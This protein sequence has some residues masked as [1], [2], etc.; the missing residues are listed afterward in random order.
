MRRMREQDLKDRDV[1]QGRKVED[2]AC[3]NGKLKDG[4]GWVI[5][6]QTEVAYRTCGDGREQFGTERRG[7]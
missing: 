2:A 4:G 1:A 6:W 7:V 3:C 5:A